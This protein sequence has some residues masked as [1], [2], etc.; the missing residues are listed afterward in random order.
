M[1]LSSGCGIYIML[2]YNRAGWY[3]GYILEGLLY[4]NF[5]REMVISQYY[6]TEELVLY[7]NYTKVYKLI[8]MA[9]R[10]SL[11]YDSES[12]ACSQSLSCVEI[13]EGYYAKM[14]IM[15]LKIIRQGHCCRWKWKQYRMF[16]LYYNN[17]NNNNG[18]FVLKHGN[19]VNQRYK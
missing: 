2:L 16:V 12:D 9:A 1:N 3:S 19:T 14:I 5:L 8:Q 15:E 13:N 10:A 4:Y 17:A 6:T 11:L 18:N 7:L